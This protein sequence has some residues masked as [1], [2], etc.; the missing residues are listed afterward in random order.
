MKNSVLVILLLVLSNCSFGASM[1]ATPPADFSLYYE[2]QEGSVPP[3]YHYEYTITVEPPNSG[4]IVYL[5]DYANFDSPTWT[6]TF[7]VNQTVMEQV[8]KQ[9]V[10]QG[11]WSRQWRASDEL[12]VGGELASLTVTAQGRKVDVPSSLG[13]GDLARIEPVYAAIHDLVP[14]ALWDDLEAR[15]TAYH[16]AKGTQR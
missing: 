14:Q 12:R 6:E 11:V 5:P 16:E 15:R 4:T 10:Q 3:P 9:M 2:W 1:P 13:N 8:Y 7:A